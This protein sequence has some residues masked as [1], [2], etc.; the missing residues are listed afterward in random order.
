MT[1]IERNEQL[2][3]AVNRMKRLE[4][5]EECISEFLKGN[6]LVSDAMGFIGKPGKELQ[7]RINDYQLETGNIVYHVTHGI[8]KFYGS[9]IFD[10][11]DFFIVSQDDE[12]ILYEREVMDQNLVQAYVYNETVPEF[13]EHGLIKIEKKNGILHKVG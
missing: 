9:E 2:N 13:S 5:S 12:S 11:F 3:E 7:R 8:Y 1:F 10:M 4:L 6:V